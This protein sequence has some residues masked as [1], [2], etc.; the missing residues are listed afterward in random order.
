MPRVGVLCIRTSEPAE[1]VDLCL[2]NERE[3]DALERNPIE[4]L[5]ARGILDV[6][7]FRRIDERVL[8]VQL[9]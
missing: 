4:P 6:L 1:L 3:R 5:V 2:S 9:P 8:L 7:C